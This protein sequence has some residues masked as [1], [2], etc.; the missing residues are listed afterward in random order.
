MDELETKIPE[1]LPIDEPD[2]E[3]ETTKEIVNN[4]ISNGVTKEELKA[5]LMEMF[6]EKK[7]DMETIVNNYILGLKGDGR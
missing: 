1:D 2:T 7:E 3:P 4:F 5:V 6:P